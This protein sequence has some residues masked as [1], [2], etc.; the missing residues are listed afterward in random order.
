[1]EERGST[2]MTLK[3]EHC[4]HEWA[5]AFEEFPVHWPHEIWCPAC[6]KLVAVKRAHRLATKVPDG[7]QLE[8]RS[9][10]LA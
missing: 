8:P 1:M 10:G 7:H 9:K 3:C 2:V 6:A 4:G 5:A